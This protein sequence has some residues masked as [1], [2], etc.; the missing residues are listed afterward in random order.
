MLRLHTSAI[1]VCHQS[2]IYFN[3][4]NLSLPKLFFKLFIMLTIIAILKSNDP[5]GNFS[6]KCLKFVMDY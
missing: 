3:K 6:K 1:N 2:K 5:S 4:T